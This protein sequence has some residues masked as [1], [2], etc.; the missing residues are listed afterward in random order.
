MLGKTLR[1]LPET[2]LPK[3]NGNLLHTASRNRGPYS[4]D[5]RR[6]ATFPSRHIGDG[7]PGG[8][9]EHVRKG[10]FR[11]DQPVQT[12]TCRLLYPESDLIAARL[13]DATGPEFDCYAKSLD[14]RYLLQSSV[15]E[16]LQQ[17]PM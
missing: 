11:P 13:N 15:I 14:N 6:P 1:V 3:P 2:K 17:Y 8:V 12:A 10:Y 7:I 16:V 9:V 4:A 5:E